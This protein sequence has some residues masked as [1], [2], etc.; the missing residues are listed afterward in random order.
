MDWNF[1]QRLGELQISNF[2][3]PGQ[4]APPAINLSGPMSTPGR[5]DSEINRFAGSLGGT[6]GQSF[7]SGFAS[8]SFARNGNDPVGGIVGNWSASNYNL[9]AN[10][11]FG[12]KQTTFNPNP[13][14]P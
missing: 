1:G 6:A 12:A 5:L 13:P 8:G 4:N 7:I 3:A 9:R 10:A 11:I 14:L 2:Q